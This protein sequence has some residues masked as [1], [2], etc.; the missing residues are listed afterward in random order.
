M[1]VIK[2]KLQARFTDVILLFKSSCRGRRGEALAK[3]CVLL[4]GWSLT[5]VVSH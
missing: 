5:K 4:Y 2:L 3:F 1:S